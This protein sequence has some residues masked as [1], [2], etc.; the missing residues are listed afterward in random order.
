MLSMRPLRYFTLCAVWLLT[1]L[2][3]VAQKKAPPREVSPICSVFATVEDQQL[4]DD[5]VGHDRE[6]QPRRSPP[7]RWQEQSDQG[8]EYE[9][10]VGDEE[11]AAGVF[12]PQLRVG[13]DPGRGKQRSERE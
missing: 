2:P 1:G 6:P 12:G 8:R 13:G 11:L 10:R 7:R 4:A 3:V 5:H 9:R